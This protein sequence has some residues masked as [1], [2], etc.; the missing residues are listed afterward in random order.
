MSINWLS[1]IV[2][3][4]KCEDIVPS[5]HLEEKLKDERVLAI[6]HHTVA[7]LFSIMYCSAQCTFPQE[8]LWNCPF[9]HLGK[10]L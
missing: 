4:E 6:V 10:K 9:F 1:P 8:A 2:A 7:Y 3:V 5:K